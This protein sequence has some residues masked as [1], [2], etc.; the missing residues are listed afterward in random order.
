MPLALRDIDPRI[1]P[2]S[3]NSAPISGSGGAKSLLWKFAPDL[4]T[5]DS[6]PSDSESAETEVFEKRV[7]DKRPH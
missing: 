3:L 4:L 6:A 5:V 1:Q 7:C 2:G